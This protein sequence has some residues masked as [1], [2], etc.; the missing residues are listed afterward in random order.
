[1][2]FSR[3]TKALKRNPYIIKVDKKTYHVLKVPSKGTAIDV[4]GMISARSKKNTVSDSKIEI[5]RD[6]CE[7]RN[8]LETPCK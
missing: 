7:H 1:M 6:T 8:H 3:K 4:D 2:S 5:D